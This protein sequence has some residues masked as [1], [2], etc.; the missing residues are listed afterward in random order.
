MGSLKAQ[1]IILVKALAMSIQGGLEQIHLGAFYPRW[2][3]DA[4]GLIFANCTFET[5][6]CWFNFI[7]TP[8]WLTDCAASLC[9]LDHIQS[10]HTLLK[11]IKDRQCAIQKLNRDVSRR[12]RNAHDAF[13]IWGD[14]KHL[15]TAAFFAETLYFN[16]SECLSLHIIFIL[17]WWNI[18]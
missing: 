16:D 3:F 13:M 10:T 8:H 17:N 14:N 9:N 5:A 18:D 2:M 1:P 15:V 12:S 4:E 6:F 7:I 11:Y